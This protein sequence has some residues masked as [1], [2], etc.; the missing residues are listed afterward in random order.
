MSVH[1]HVQPNFLSTRSADQILFFW[2]LR[3]QLL[4]VKHM[5][6]SIVHFNTCAYSWESVFM[7]ELVYIS[8]MKC[9]YRKSNWSDNSL[10]FQVINYELMPITFIIGA[11]ICSLFSC[12]RY[13]PTPFNDRSCVPALL[14]ALYFQSLNKCVNALLH[15]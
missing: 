14:T 7:L 4:W 1:R 11:D 12:T 3:S 2:S 15:I 10:C 5:H 6:I 13:K 8:I 9:I